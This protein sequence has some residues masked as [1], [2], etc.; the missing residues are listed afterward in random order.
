MAGPPDL[1]AE[2]AARLRAAEQRYTANR[3]AV[4][5]VLE[6][7]TRPLTIAEILDRGGRLAQSSVYRNVVVLEAAGVAHRVVSTD[8]FARYELGEGLTDH[9]HHHLI[10][11]GCGA[12]AD[13]TVPSDVESSLV[14][15]FEAAAAEHGFTADTHRL[16]LVGLCRRCG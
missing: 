5:D 1:H 15:A 11:S 8:E 7:A 2:V 6:A 13:F 9:H 4:V 10:C 14:S 3:R 12:V 16:D